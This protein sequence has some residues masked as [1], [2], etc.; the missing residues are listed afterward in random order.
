MANPPAFGARLKQL[1]QQHGLTQEMLAERVGYAAETIRKIESGLRRPSHQVATKLAEE[2]GIAPAECANFVHLAREAPD[3]QAA[4]LTVQAAAVTFPVTPVPN[5]LPRP[6]TP[7][8]GREQEVLDAQQRL[9][10]EEMRLLSLVGPGGVGKTRLA[11]EVAAGLTGQFDD[12]VVFVNLV[13][14]DDPELVI[15]TI[16]DLLDIGEEGGQPRLERL[17]AGLHARQML[18]VIDNFEQVVGAAPYVAELLAACPGLKALVTSREL[19]RVRG[20]HVL[21]VLPLALPDIAQATTT[22]LWRSAAVQ[23]F[24]ARA[25]AVNPAF[26]ITD[27]NLLT[28]AELCQRLD[29]LPLA[30]ELAAA[31]IT[32]FSPE[33]MLARLGREPKLCTGGPRDLPARQ[34]TLWNTI[35]WSYDLLTPSEQQL[36]R[37]LC[38]FTGGRTL[39]AIE[40]VCRA[41]G[42][43]VL[44]IVDGLA[45]LSNKS[46]LRQV[47]MPDGEPRFLMLETI[48]K[49]GL[50]Q[51]EQSGE[52]ETTRRAHAHYYTQL[53]AQAERQLWGAGQEQA[54]ARLE[55][56]HNNLRAA[57]TW[58]LARDEGVVPALDMAGCLWRFWNIRGHW[59]EGLRWLEQALE[60]RAQTDPK[61]IWLALHGA[62]NL[63]L[64]LGDYPRAR[65]Y[66]EESLAVTRCLD[67]P[68]A[69]ANSLLNLSVAILYQ[70]QLEEAI[71]LQEQAL[72]IHREQNNLIGIALAL[73][74]LAGMFEKQ[75]DYQRAAA[76][77]EQ[78]LALYQ[79]LGDS[80]GTA[81]AIHDLALLAHRRGSYER[82][83]QLLDEC[84]AI[85]YRL[86][87]KNDLAQV[88]NDL[89]ELVAE[90]GDTKAARVLYSESLKLA[91]E[92][93]DRRCQ[94]T[95]FHNLGQ[96]ALQGG[97]E[98]QAFLLYN[99]SLALWRD[100]GDSRHCSQVQQSLESFHLHSAEHRGNRMYQV[101]W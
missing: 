60:R 87:S 27:A 32:L 5:N 55:Q 30:I 86:E 62:G 67:K 48:W 77:A 58:Y 15:P 100:L 64:D 89:G 85:Y 53:V 74:N 65:A 83:R 10:C 57:L 9:L 8:I 36:F 68:N 34:Q 49:Y 66:Y 29:G 6:L 71:T 91:V 79:Q 14:I 23:L 4:G 2:F 12:G 20:E 26:V 50:E 69:I 28:V 84:E 1:R 40:A 75:R 59:S 90:Q 93:G 45:S 21:P 3:Q 54:L 95:V 56:E 39:D 63:A 52:A 78:S 31:R 24:S 94:A 41:A 17:K 44:D 11:L 82:A 18:L 13:P 33:A 72:A 80:R 92:L 47:V 7:L 16:A 99:K 38:V 19:L 46:L 42:D 76:Y 35:A 61:H 101:A 25:Q 51:L 98:E 37:R 81:W 43:S 88:L 73:H 97:D 22:E 96:L 70:G